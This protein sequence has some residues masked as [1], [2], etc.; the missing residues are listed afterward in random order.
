MKLLTQAV[1]KKLERFPLYSQTTRR[2]EAKIL[3]K[4]F[5]PDAQWSWFVLEALEVERAGAGTDWQFFG[6]VSNDQ[7]TAYG[8]FSF[9]EICGARGGLGLPIER[10]M[11]FHIKTVGELR[12]SREIPSG[13]LDWMDECP[14]DGL[15]ATE[16]EVVNRNG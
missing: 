4:F 9:S 2:N 8:Y 5:T 3:V 6:I 15:P 16:R 12:E 13:C 10:D 14:V 7:E 11:H 1:L